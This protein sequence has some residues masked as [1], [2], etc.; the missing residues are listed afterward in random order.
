MRWVGDE[1]RLVV[2]GGVVPPHSKG[3]GFG[4]ARHGRT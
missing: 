1:L 3:G 2:Q 4:R